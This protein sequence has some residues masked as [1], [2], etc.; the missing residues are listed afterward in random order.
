MRRYSIYLFTLVFALVPAKSRGQRVRLEQTLSLRQAVEVALKNNPT[1]KASAA[2]A[3]AVRQGITVARASRYPRV[4]FSEAFT[5][6]NNPVYVFGTLL[7]QRQFNASDFALN[8]LNT[9]LPLDNFLTQF[10]SVM[11]LYN[12]GQTSRRIHDAQL[13]SQIARHQQART[14]QELIF[15]VIQAYSNERLAREAVGVAKSSVETAQSDLKNAQ[16]RQEQ[17]MAVPSDLLSAQVQLAGAQEDLLRAENG[18]ELAHAA[19]NASMGLPA[20]APTRIEG[21]LT[22]AQLDAGLLE[23]RQTQALLKRP[24]YLASQLGRERAENG[25]HLARAVFQP[26]IN[27]FSSWGLDNQTLTTRGGNNWAAGATLTF[28]ILDGGANLARLTAAHARERQ[29]VA[30][31]AQMATGIRLQVEEAFLNL[32]TAAKRVQVSRDAATQATESLRILQNRYQAGL[33]T[34]TSVLQAETARTAAEKN[35]LSAVYDYRLSYAALELATGELSPDSP[36]VL[37]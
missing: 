32:T 12:A 26:Q 33:A 30:I 10:T 14:R 22:E 9:P 17:G 11:P 23:E 5:R 34:L 25:I 8:V 31:Q 28:N 24:D 20:D 15:Q 36:A 7:T 37:K 3:E 35:Y 21:R 2:Y 27:L 6:G 19:L 1:V 29:A 16:S 18:V 13:K 4:D